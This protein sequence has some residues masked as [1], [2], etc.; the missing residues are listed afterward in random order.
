MAIREAAR[1]RP[2]VPGAVSYRI[3]DRTSDE[4]WAITLSGG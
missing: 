2:T 1:R 3:L 4:P